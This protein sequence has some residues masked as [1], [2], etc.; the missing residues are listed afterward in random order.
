MQP[1]QTCSLEQLQ[2]SQPFSTRLMQ[3]SESGD[4]FVQF[5]NSTKYVPSA[6]EE[7]SVPVQT[8]PRQPCSTNPMHP[9]FELQDTCSE[10][11]AT[12]MPV[13]PDATELSQPVQCTSPP[14]LFYMQ[15]F[16]YF[17]RAE[18]NTTDNVS[19]TAV[20]KWQKRPMHMQTPRNIFDS[21]M[22]LLYI[23]AIVVYYMLLH[24]TTYVFIARCDNFNADL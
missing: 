15:A 7:S 21:N 5:S 10:E 18:S 19:A 8:E 24:I 1:L 3:H 16:S 22:L 14:A 23:P 4:K 13:Q 9:C 17:S 11:S 20:T 12:E 2:S 6:I